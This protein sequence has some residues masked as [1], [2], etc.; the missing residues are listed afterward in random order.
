MSAAAAVAEE[1]RLITFE[2]GGSV[3]ALPIANVLEVAEASEMAC[4]PTLPSSIGGVMNYHGD[5]LPVLRRSSLLDL[6]GGGLEDADLPEPDHVLVLATG[7]RGGPGLG[8]PVDRILGLVDGAGA[9]ARGTEAVAERRTI[10]GRVACVLDPQRLLSRAQE[11]IER[12]FARS[13]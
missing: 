11:V 1:G 10:D 9:V 13:A 3:Y 12:S 2:V 4:V 6:R 8:M 7:E 5:A